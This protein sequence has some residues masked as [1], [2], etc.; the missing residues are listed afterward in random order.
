MQIKFKFLFT[1][2]ELDCN[3]ELKEAILIKENVTIVT[4]VKINEIKELIS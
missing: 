3:A 4:K 1:A 2:D